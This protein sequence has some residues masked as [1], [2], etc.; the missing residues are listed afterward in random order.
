M[1]VI[2]EPE[3]RGCLVLRG[4]VTALQGEK[5][6]MEMLAPSPPKKERKK[7]YLYK[8]KKNKG[9]LKKDC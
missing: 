1:D 8:K 4:W 7:P 3:D 5:Q 6:T 9:K 2:V